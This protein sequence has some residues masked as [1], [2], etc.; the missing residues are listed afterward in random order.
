MRLSLYQASQR[1]KAAHARFSLWAVEAEE[2]RVSGLNRV[3]LFS[4]EKDPAGKME[5]KCAW[6]ALRS[7]CSFPIGVGAC[8]LLFCSGMINPE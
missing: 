2:E 4:A 6:I 1:V 8:I 7:L 3:R 5:S